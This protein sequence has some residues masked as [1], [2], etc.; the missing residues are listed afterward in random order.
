MASLASVI[1]PFLFFNVNNQLQTLDHI[2]E[3]SGESEEIGGVPLFIKDANKYLFNAMC[4]RVA[5]LLI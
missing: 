1:L 5:S 4:G 2:Q 3:I